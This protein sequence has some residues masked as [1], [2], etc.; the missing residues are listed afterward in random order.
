MERAE[1]CID[2][3]AACALLGED[4][5]VGESEW[6]TIDDAFRA[7]HPGLSQ[8]ELEWAAGREAFDALK[9]RLG[10][11]LSFVWRKPAERR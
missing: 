8:R 7:K 9:A 1:I 4:L 6:V 10:R 3:N 11:P 2:G 5:A